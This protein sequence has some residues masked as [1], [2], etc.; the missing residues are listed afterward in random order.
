MVFSE[1]EQNVDRLEVK[2]PADLE[3]PPESDAILFNPDARSDMQPC[4]P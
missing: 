2:R 1:E 4:E 3:R